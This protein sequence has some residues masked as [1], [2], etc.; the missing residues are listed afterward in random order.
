MSEPNLP[1]AK[2]EIIVGS[3][4][5]HKVE[6]VRN[7]ARLLVPGEHLVYGKPAKSGVSEQP[8]GM[9]ETMRGA[10]NRAFEVWSPGKIA[11]GIEGGLIDL[12]L[13]VSFEGNLE[14][15]PAHLCMAVIAVMNRDGKMYFSTSAGMQFPSYAVV[16]AK[17][18]GISVGKVLAEKFGGDHTDP[19]A[20]LSF[21]RSHRRDSIE[22]AVK[23]ALYNI[24]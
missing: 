5:V 3:E 10:I 17:K 2:I 20:I 15:D 14:V 23:L 19:R 16:E 12:P 9:A 22:E 6:P 1:S 24:F 4:S 18:R 11:I 7:V 13:S 21:D 8:Y